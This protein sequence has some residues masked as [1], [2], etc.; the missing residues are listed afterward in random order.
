MVKIKIDQK[1]K[2]EY[3]DGTIISGKIIKIDGNTITVQGP[4][5]KYPIQKEYLLKNLKS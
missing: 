5:Y 2:F 1:V 3:L 4:K